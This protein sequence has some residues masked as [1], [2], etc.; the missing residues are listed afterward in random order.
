MRE[1]PAS[2]LKT[3]YLEQLALKLLADPSG[4]TAVILLNH[5]IR[6]KKILAEL[7][8]PYFHTAEWMAYG[9]PYGESWEFFGSGWA[10]QGKKKRPVLKSSHRGSKKK[11][12]G[13][14]AWK[15]LEI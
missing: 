5:L 13:N 2:P 4:E 7:E 6:T 1:E 8:F 15:G 10:G 3:L 11:Y 9:K 14:A 12:G